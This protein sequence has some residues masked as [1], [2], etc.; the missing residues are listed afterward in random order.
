MEENI[1]NNTGT[2][3]NEYYDILQTEDC[4]TEGI[5]VDKQM[6]TSAN[7]FVG[8]DGWLT[9]EQ[10]KQELELLQMLENKK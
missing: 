1:K 9:P 3:K 7:V 2:D 6:L 5:N 10:I 4:I 8:R